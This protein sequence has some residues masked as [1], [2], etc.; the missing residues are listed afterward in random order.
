MQQKPHGCSRARGNNQG[1][2]T[3]LAADI[4]LQSRPPSRLYIVSA[5]ERYGGIAFCWRL[6]SLDETVQAAERKAARVLQLLWEDR[7]LRNL[8]TVL[9]PG[10]TDFVSRP[11]SAASARVTTSKATPSFLSISG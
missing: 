5:V 1:A 3:A 8:E 4:V 10:H 11:T 9:L 7:E 6:A 2:G